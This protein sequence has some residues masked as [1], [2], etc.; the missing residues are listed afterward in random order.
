MDI[1]IRRGEEQ[2]G[3]LTPEQLQEGL[4][5]GVP[6]GFPEYIIPQTDRLWLTVLPPKPPEKKDLEKADK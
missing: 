5:N 4:N 2:F 1:Y 6:Q 3:P